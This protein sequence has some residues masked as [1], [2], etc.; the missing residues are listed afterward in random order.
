MF[1]R[2]SLWDENDVVKHGKQIVALPLNAGGVRA[3]ADLLKEKI[4]NGK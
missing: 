3:V 4:G 2:W 1:L